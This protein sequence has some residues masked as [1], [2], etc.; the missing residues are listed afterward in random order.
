VKTASI[1]IYEIWQE[2]AP[3]LPLMLVKMS[4]LVFKNMSESLKKARLEVWCDG[5]NIFLFFYFIL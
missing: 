1:G 5:E 2:W 4:F 3:C